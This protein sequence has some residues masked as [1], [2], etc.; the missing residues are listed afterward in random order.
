MLI[1]LRLF[2]VLKLKKIVRRFIDDVSPVS[3]VFH[4]VATVCIE[5]KYKLRMETSIP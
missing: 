1:M 4:T 3:P 2:V 5:L